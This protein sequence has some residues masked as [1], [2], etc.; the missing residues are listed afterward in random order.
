MADKL[1]SGD[2]FYK[3]VSNDDSEDI[4]LV[5][6]KGVNDVS[7]I[8]TNG[9]Q[10][11][12]SKQSLEENYVKLIPDGIVTFSIVDTG[13]VNDKDTKDILVSLYK[14]DD[15]NDGNNIPYVVCRQNIQDFFTTQI[16]TN[17]YVQYAGLCMS[18]NSCP[19]G[20]QFEMILACNGILNNVGVSIY[21]DDSLEDILSLINTSKYDSLL[22]DMHSHI[23]FNVVGHCKSL[24]EL[25]V[26]NEFMYEFHTTFDI[27][28]VKFDTEIIRN[29]ELH[30]EQRSILEEIIKCE[31]FKTYV[32][33]FDREIDLHEIQRSYIMISDS[34]ND[35]Y[36]IAYDKG[37]Y[38]NETYKKG[39]KDQRDV[40]AMLKNIKKY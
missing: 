26:D 12:I 15:L 28:E 13:K 16:N 36:I 4:R 7:V 5:R 9:K 27:I 8:Q 33:P 11:K 32:I 18:K 6:F 17:P 34:K 20:V 39:N 29:D 10:F 40:I 19:E 21:L 23:A 3:K 24:K 22:Q 14:T 38:L 31:M 30:P 2:R 35:I 1:M 25:L 37:E